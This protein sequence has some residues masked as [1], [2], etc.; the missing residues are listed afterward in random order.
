MTGPEIPEQ[1]PPPPYVPRLKM[2]REPVRRINVT[3]AAAERFDA[4]RA[5]HGLDR[6]P[7]LERLLD[8]AGTKG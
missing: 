7:A 8:L 1:S 3:P 5:E 4:W 2:R 6:S